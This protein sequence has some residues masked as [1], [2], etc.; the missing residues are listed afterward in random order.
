M[1]YYL[2]A[3]WEIENYAQK[4]ALQEV[5]YVRGVFNTIITDILFD[6]NLVPKFAATPEDILKKHLRPALEDAIKKTLLTL[7]EETP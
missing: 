2:I 3:E 5:D 7:E 6:S 1:T 4:K